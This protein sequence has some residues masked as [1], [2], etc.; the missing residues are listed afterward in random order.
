MPVAE[1]PDGS[2]ALSTHPVAVIPA[3]PLAVVPRRST[4]IT[5]VEHVAGMRPARR[6]M[7]W[8]GVLAAAALTA[9]VGWSAGVR[10]D[11]HTP[12]VQASLATV[13]LDVDVAPAMPALVPPSFEAP[14]VVAPVAAPARAPIAVVGR[15]RVAKAPAAPRV[16]TQAVAAPVAAAPVVADPGTPVVQTSRLLATRYVEVGRALR[17]APDELW[18]R[19]RLIRI[20]DALGSETSRK[21]ALVSLA[22]IERAIH[23]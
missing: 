2:D 10:P 7:A 21:Q 11:V 15:K 16:A 14:A 13:A 18:A 20:N 1:L 23:R 12:R 22:E 6:R 4:K 5:R 9:V 3:P 19:Y 8:A 17:G